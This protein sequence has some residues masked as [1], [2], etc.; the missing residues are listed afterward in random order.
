MKKYFLILI[1]IPFIIGTCKAQSN[2]AYQT[3]TIIFT[4][5]N[6]TLTALNLSGITPKWQQKYTQG[7]ALITGASQLA[8]GIYQTRTNFFTLNAINIA[9]G[10]ATV[11]TNGILLYQLFHPTKKKTSWNLYISPVK[12]NNPEFGFRVVK[13]FKI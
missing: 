1:A 5:F 10:T 6:S 7:I 4:A 3:G 13:Y 12:K 2:S 9:A 8:Y 11:I